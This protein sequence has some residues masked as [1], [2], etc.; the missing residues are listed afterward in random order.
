MPYSQF[1]SLRAV[2]KQ[3][4]LTEKNV[5]LFPAI[6]PVQPSAWLS[7]TLSYVLSKKIAFV[8]EKS[9]SEG[10]VFPVLLEME[11]RNPERF[12]LYSGVTIEADKDKGLNGECD[13]VLSRGEQSLELSTPVF[14][15]VEAKDNDLELGVPQCVAQLVGAQIFN[16]QEGNIV[17]FIFGGVTTGDT[18]LFLKLEGTTVF[19]DNQY[20]Y[21]A[22]LTELLGMLQ[23]IVY[24]YN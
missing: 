13:F 9:R 18:W 24:Q 5:S 20:F 23:T 12:S 21:I 17:P 14:C 15:I 2:K 6:E 8:S 10:I 4:G 16:Q 22:N 3:F 7:E 1:S 19:I 11:R